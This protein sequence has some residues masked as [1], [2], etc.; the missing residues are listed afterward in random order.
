MGHRCHGNGRFPTTTESPDYNWVLLS[1]LLPWQQGRFPGEH[2]QAFV[3]VTTFWPLLEWVGGGSPSNSSLQ[4]MPPTSLVLMATG[5]P[6]PLSPACTH[7]LAPVEEGLLI[8]LC[9]G[10]GQVDP[11][12]SYLL[13]LFNS[14]PAARP[15]SEA[16]L[17]AGARIVTPPGL[18][19]PIPSDRATDRPLICASV[20]SPGDRGMFPSC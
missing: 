10:G 15:K 19:G 14:E 4:T 5:T 9:Q 7:S 17:T 3:A 1:S 6:H 16:G 12:H 20:S 13:L 18:L 11:W 8:R 2:H